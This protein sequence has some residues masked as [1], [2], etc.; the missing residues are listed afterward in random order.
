MAG[1][2]IVALAGGIHAIRDTA[3]NVQ[4]HFDFLPLSLGGIFAANAVT[5]WA[6]KFIGEYEIQAGTTGEA[7]KSGSYKLK[8]S[9]ARLF[10]VESED[11][12][13]LFLL[14][15]AFVIGCFCFVLISRAVQAQVFLA[16]NPAYHHFIVAALMV[17]FVWWAGTEDS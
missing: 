5:V 6:S 9:L 1:N 11:S 15:T 10:S 3:A 13:S 12:K 2:G 4:A 7:K 8:H 17:L 16:I 14:L